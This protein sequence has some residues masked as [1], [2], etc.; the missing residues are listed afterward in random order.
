MAVVGGGGGDETTRVHACMLRSYPLMVVVVAALVVGC[1]GG[2]AGATAAGPRNR[3]SPWLEPQRPVLE[4][5]SASDATDRTN[6]G[7]LAVPRLDGSA[8]PV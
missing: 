7:R 3:R 5:G 2:G 4:P 1:S 8:I 6:R